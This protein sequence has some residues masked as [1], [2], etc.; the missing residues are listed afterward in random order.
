M[1]KTCPFSCSIIYWP[2]FE[3]VLNHWRLMNMY[4]LYTG[5][6]SWPRCRHIVQQWWWQLH[7]SSYANVIFYNVV[8]SLDRDQCSLSLF[9]RNHTSTFRKSSVTQT[10]KFLNHHLLCTGALQKQSQ[11]DLVWGKHVYYVKVL[12]SFQASRLCCKAAHRA[13]LFVARL[14]VFVSNACFLFHTLTQIIHST[15]RNV[16]SAWK[17]W[18]FSLTNASYDSWASKG[19][20]SCIAAGVL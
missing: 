4:L 1:W 16:P 3:W 13:A 9:Y 6:P 12:V 10:I 11:S 5:S 14:L 8:I 18:T 7:N 17:W 20:F 19:I 15:Y 2:D